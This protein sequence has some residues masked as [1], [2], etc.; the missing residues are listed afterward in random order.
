MDAVNFFTGQ[1]RQTASFD[2]GL[3]SARAQ[4]FTLAVP[5]WLQAPLRQDMRCVVT[6]MRVEVPNCDYVE[7]ITPLK[8]VYWV[9]TV[10]EVCGACVPSCSCCTHF[11]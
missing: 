5:Q 8:G 1:T 10:M 9:A 6:G 11:F 7:S 2:W 4:V 3:L